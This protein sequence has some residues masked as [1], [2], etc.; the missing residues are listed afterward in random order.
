[1]LLSHKLTE[2]YLFIQLDA[3]TGKWREK[4]IQ[5]FSWFFQCSIP[6]KGEV[7]HLMPY[8]DSAQ[9]VRIGSRS[10]GGINTPWHHEIIHWKAQ[11]TKGWSI[12][13]A[14]SGSPSW[15]ITYQAF[16]IKYETRQ[17]TTFSFAACIIL[18]CNVLTSHT[19]LFPALHS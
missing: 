13:R 18:V 19:G 11:T 7:G 8:S 3:T 16:F 10:K 2:G 14:K 17:I 6:P 12:G 15:E 5:Q 1:M 4:S 9:I